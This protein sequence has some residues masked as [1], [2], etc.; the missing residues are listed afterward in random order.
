MRYRPR[1]ITLARGRFYR[2]RPRPRPPTI[3]SAQVGVNLAGPDAAAA[4]DKIFAAFEGT[5]KPGCALGVWRE[6][7]I[8]YTRGYGMAN[9][10]YN[11]PITPETIFEAGSVSK[12][13]AAAAIQLLCRRREARPRRRRPKTRSRSPRSSGR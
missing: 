7:K 11:V 4:I 12:Q 1:I 3:A 10:E 2:R 9:L 13:F 5:T 6:G 8:V